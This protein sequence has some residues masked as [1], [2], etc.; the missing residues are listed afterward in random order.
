MTKTEQIIAD[1]DRIIDEELDL[2]NSELA[3]ILETVKELVEIRALE[4]YANPYS[5]DYEMQ[6]IRH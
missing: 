5:F 4:L 1:I 2:F 3:V 6:K